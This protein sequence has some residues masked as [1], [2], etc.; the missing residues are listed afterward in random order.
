MS[1]PCPMTLLSF[2]LSIWLLYNRAGRLLFLPVQGSYLV[3][4][5]SQTRSIPRRY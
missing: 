2:C 5:R 4:M 1:Q 3:L